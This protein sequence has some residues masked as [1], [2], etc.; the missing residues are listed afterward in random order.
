MIPVVK[1]TGASLDALMFYVSVLGL[2]L[3]AG[4]FL[5]LKI[6]LL[7]QWFMPAALVAG[8]LGL[9]LGPY[10]LEFFHEEM[11][12]AWALIPGRLITIVFAP[13]LMGVIIPNP[14]KVIN[15]MGPQAM[16]TLGGDFLQIAVPFLLTAL[17]FSPYWQ[18]NPLFGTIVELG[19]AGGHGT[20]GGMT[21]VFKEL[22]W[23]DGTT[24]S[25]M[26]ATVGLFL[27]IVSGMI[28]IN[29]GIRKGYTSVI[30]STEDIRKDEPEIIVA[31]N[32]KSG[33]MVTINKDVID[34]FALHFSLIGIAI[35]LGWIMQKALATWVKGIPL[36]PLAMLGGLLVQ[37]ILSKTPWAVLV[38]RKTFQRIQGWA[39]EFLIVA[40]VASLKIPIIIAYAMP[41]TI[42]MFV[43]SALLIGYFFWAGKR[44]FKEDWFENAIVAYGSLTAV[45]AVGLLLL[46]TVDPEMKTNAGV[47]YA[48]R[49]P[50]ISPIVGGGILSASLPVIIA[51]YGALNSGLVFLGLFFAVL[52]ICK[53][54]GWWHPVSKKA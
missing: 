53:M 38:D 30:K 5:R 22:G 2:L 42:V 17:V 23:P 28:I 6:R 33:S 25:L 14:K 1:I 8:A 41:L 50:F 48:L 13:M 29:F 45:A 11:V 37:I 46:R 51:Q 31:E 7:K 47:A 49:G 43:M 27:G 52:V 39:L 12:N 44:I 21:E 54:A 34:S 18:T 19:F 24:L 10:G 15:M 9:A 20:A 35:L 4:V 26:T 3:L 32:Q 16:F 36:F 40:A